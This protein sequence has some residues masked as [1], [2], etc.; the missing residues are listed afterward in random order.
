VCNRLSLIRIELAMSDDFARRHFD[1]RNSLPGGARPGAFASASQRASFPP[2]NEGAAFP[3]PALDRQN[4]RWPPNSGASALPP[5]PRPS[6]AAASLPPAA[7]YELAMMQA[8]REAMDAEQL[9]LQRMSQALDFGARRR[10]SDVSNLSG[11]PNEAPP[12]FGVAG[13][14]AASLYSDMAASEERLRKRRRLN[15]SSTTMIMLNK[16]GNSFPMPP[17]KGNKGRDIGIKSMDTFQKIWEEYD[18]R[19]KVLFPDE[20]EKQKLYVKWRFAPVVGG[21]RIVV[22][23]MSKSD[24][25]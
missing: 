4:P 13:Q 1:G 7:S 25:E 11:T 5:P 3:P 20:V 23:A 9:R 12:P 19:A 2:P 8:Q 24:D 6:A 17:L 21:R 22:S 18:A 14:H 15:S 10:M 16:T